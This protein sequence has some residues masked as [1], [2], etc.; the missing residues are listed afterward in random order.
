MATV[1]DEDI[2]DDEQLE[3]LLSFPADVQEAIDQVSSCPF[4]L[5]Y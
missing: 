1:D 5:I 2:V 3:S 4:L